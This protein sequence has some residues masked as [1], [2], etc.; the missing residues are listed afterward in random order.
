VV[1]KDVQNWS[2]P[3]GRWW[4]AAATFIV[5]YALKVCRAFDQT[6]IFHLSSN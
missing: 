4:P 3:L 2:I 1:N 5:A 6:V